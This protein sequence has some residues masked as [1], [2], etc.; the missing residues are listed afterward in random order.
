MEREL[1]SILRGVDLAL[2]AASSRAGDGV[3]ELPLR[4]G[5]GCWVSEAGLVL[6][7]ASV[8]AGRENE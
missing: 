1:G 7:G 3:F 4:A 6:T 2:T 5:G 8:E